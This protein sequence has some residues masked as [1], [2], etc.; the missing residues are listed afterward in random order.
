[1]LSQGFLA[2]SVKTRGQ[3]TE[4][5]DGGRRTEGRGQKAEGGGQRAEGGGQDERSNV[6]GSRFRGFQQ[7]P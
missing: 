4:G 3:R 6:K 2:Q 5:R 1:M 7:Y